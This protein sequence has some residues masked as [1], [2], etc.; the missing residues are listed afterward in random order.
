MSN[1][2]VL[3]SRMFMLNR[4]EAHI[5]KNILVKT[6]YVRKICILC[7][8]MTFAK[9]KKKKNNNRVK[10]KGEHLRTICVFLSVT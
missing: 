5:I 8:R 7:V 9:K 3:F 1:I 2:S 4:N 10:T 6:R